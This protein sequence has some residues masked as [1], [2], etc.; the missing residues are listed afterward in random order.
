MKSMHALRL[1]LLPAPRLSAVLFVS[2]LMLARSTSTG[3]L[4]LAAALALAVPRL[5]ARWRP[6]RARPGRAGLVLRLAWRVLVDV[7]KANVEVAYHVLGR[8]SVLH[9]AWVW[10]PLR[11]RDAHGVVTLAHIITLTPGTISSELSAD[12]HHL[13]VHALHCLDTAALVAL[14]QARYEAPLME[15]FE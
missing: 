4:L 15:I 11:I 14:I 8:D 12:R 10:V 13:L 5:I 7:L 1:G 2:W 3:Q 9:P 6:A